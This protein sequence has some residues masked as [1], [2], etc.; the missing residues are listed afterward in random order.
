MADMSISLDLNV[1]WHLDLKQTDDPDLIRIRADERPPGTI[2]KCTEWFFLFVANVVEATGGYSARPA[3]WYSA[4][5]T[6]LNMVI[7][8]ANHHLLS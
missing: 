7:V 3:K 1:S 5:Q 2:L 8:S 4:V 6:G